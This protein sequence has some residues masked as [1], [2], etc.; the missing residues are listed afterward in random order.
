MMR[1]DGEWRVMVMGEAGG[2]V[3]NDEMGKE[4]RHEGTWGK[5]IDVNEKGVDDLK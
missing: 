4:K 1:K 2:W 5:G 3:K